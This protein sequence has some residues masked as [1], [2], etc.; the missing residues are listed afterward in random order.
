[1]SVAQAAEIFSLTMPVAVTN[2]ESFEDGG[3]VKGQLVDRQG[4]RVSFR[5]SRWMS[6]APGFALRIPEKREEGGGL[7]GHSPSVDYWQRPHDIPVV[8]GHDRMQLPDGFC[9]H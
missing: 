9:R 3:T 2:T 1:M 7:S 5:R 8:G 4:R 6:E